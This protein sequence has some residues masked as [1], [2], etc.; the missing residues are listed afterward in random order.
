MAIKAGLEVDGMFMIGLPTETEDDIEKTINFAIELNVRYAIFNIFVPY[1]G[2]EFYD[3][4]NKEGKIKFKDWS[5]FTSYPTYSGG[6]PVYIPDGL[7]KIGLMQLQKKA[8]RKFYLRPKF[9]YNELR[10]FKLSMMRQ[11]WNGLVALVGKNKK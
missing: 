4:L 6:E 5:D 8:M 7:T 1:P 10:N 2:C 11:Y 3:V 9:I